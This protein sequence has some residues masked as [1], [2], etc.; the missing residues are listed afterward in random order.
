MLYHST[1]STDHAVDA[2]TAIVQGLSDDGGLFVSDALGEKKIDLAMPSTIVLL[3]L[4]T[5][6]IP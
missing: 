6:S 5:V 3:S 1:R 4:R 2:R